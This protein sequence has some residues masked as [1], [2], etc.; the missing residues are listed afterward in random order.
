MS[1]NVSQLNRKNFVKVHEDTLYINPL[2]PEL[3]IE[4]ICKDTFSYRPCWAILD[5]DMTMEK[6][7]H[8]FAEIYV[9]TQGKGTMLLGSET[10]DV[11]A[12]MSVN[13]PGDMAHEVTNPDT[14]VEP[15]I[16]VS[17]GLKL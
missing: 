5:A 3:D 13:I 17:V 9:F 10:F 8:P 12:G 6:H 1:K 4:D 7:D 11:C 2:F 16:W 14:A 15:L